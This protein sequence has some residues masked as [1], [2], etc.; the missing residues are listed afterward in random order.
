[1][2]WQSHY[3]Q[4]IEPSTR[5]L[6]LLHD[7]DRLVLADETMQQGLQTFG[8]NLL[9]FEDS[10]TFRHH[11]ETDYRAHWD[12]GNLSPKL[13]IL[14]ESDPYRALPFDVWQTAQRLEIS[15]VNLFP[16]LNVTLIATLTPT[17]LGE[18]YHVQQLTPPPPSGY[19]QS[20]DYLLRHLYHLTLESIQ[21]PI[22]LLRLLLQRHHRNQQL[23]PALDERLI[24]L[25]Q[26]NPT[27]KAWPLTEII[28]QRQPFFRYLQQ[29]WGHYLDAQL[30]RERPASSYHAPL[31]FES[32]DIRVYIDT[33]FL[34]GHL[35]PISH[36]EAEKLATEWYAIGLARDPI[37]EQQKRFNQLLAK[38]TLPQATDPHTAWLTFAP[39]W[40]ELVVA[41]HQTT[42]T[43]EAESHFKQLQHDLDQ[44]FT[45]WLLQNYGRLSNQLAPAPVL[46]HHT[47]R[48]L[49]HQRPAKVALLVLDGLA[50]DQWLILRKVLFQQRPTLKLHERASF[51]WLPTLTSVARQAIFSGLHP[52]QYADSI[53]TTHKEEAYWRAYWNSKGVPPTAILYEKAIRDITQVNELPLHDARL[54]V[55]GLVIDSIDQMMHGIVLGT[56]GMHNQTQQWAEQGIL[57]TLLER[58]LAA[59]FRIYL[60]ADH[61]NIEATGCGRPSEGTIPS[62][63]G[64]RVRIY[65]SAILRQT[66]ELQFPNTIAWPPN[67]G[68]PHDY[69]PL[70]APHRQAFT[71]V[72]QTTV[73]HGGLAL[74][75]VIVP[76]I[77]IG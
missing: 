14:I 52:T 69:Q 12:K 64:E 10:L 36:P 30:I 42:L 15:L 77:E 35:T 43:Y 13:V 19:T 60:T 11:Y 27:F 24:K 63:R 25:L 37:A 61:G 39:K 28:P 70:F 6:I 29:E 17:D 71:T 4:Q 20:C 55:V 1:M 26:N 18:L 16:H 41:K 75:E 53:H 33:L 56:A 51:A 62:Q 38:T 46:G 67:I 40:A 5:P 74:E 72:G 44:R 66:T 65:Q 47:P 3:L 23:P 76:F 22:D 2:N 31:P 34:E 54:Q 45:A 9:L 73:T 48:F 68:L 59:N 50:Y 7:P 58:L 32:A 57:A 49:T 21:T 8:Y